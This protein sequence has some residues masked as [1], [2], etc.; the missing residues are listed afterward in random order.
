MVAVLRSA[1]RRALCALALVA[2]ASAVGCSPSASPG[3]AQAPLEVKRAYQTGGTDKVKPTA[4]GQA[5]VAV[6]LVLRNIGG[7]DAWPLVPALFSIETDSGLQYPGD[8]QTALYPGGC[9]ARASLAA[10]KTTECVVLFQAPLTA[11]AVQ[12]AYKKPDASALSAPLTVT[13][14]TICAG[15][16]VDVQTDPKNCGACGKDIGTLRCVDGAADC[17]GE[18]VACSGRCVDTQTT[19]AH[20]GGCGNYCDGSR[21]VAGR[22]TVVKASTDRVSCDT[23]CGS[24]ACIGASAYYSNGV[25]DFDLPLSCSALPPRGDVKDPETGCTAEWGTYKRISCD[26]AA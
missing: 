4:A 22:C 17:P 2:A 21:C 14:C 24:A 13:P 12:L 19:L 9:D 3:A 7:T 25:C 1:L 16:C 6:E 8:P 23:V 20:C 11:V 5:F 10:D 15:R 26:C 18:Q